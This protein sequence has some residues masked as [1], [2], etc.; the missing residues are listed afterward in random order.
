MQDLGGIEDLS[1]E[2]HFEMKMRRGADHAGAADGTEL[3][4]ASQ[5]LAGYDLD[6]FEVH[7]ASAQVVT[8]ASVTHAYEAS[9]SPE[10]S[11][12]MGVV[13]IAGHVDV[14]LVP[15]QID[16]GK[17]DP[18]VGDDPNGFAGKR[19]DVDAAV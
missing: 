8:F 12:G 6:L 5:L 15:R 3:I 7:V 1:R 10:A 16:P 13:A 19:L 9:P 4:A 14:T 18:T 17:T 11:T 2:V